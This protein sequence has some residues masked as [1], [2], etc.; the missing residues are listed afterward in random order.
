MCCEGRKGG[1]EEEEGRC[2]CERGRDSDLLHDRRRRNPAEV[3]N[4]EDTVKSSC[5]SSTKT[6]WHFSSTSR[7][8]IRSG[9]G[10]LAHDDLCVANCKVSH[11]IGQVNTH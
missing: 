4:G 6:L 3:N 9:P 2:D 11:K 8:P 1:T 7:Q 10:Q 5:L